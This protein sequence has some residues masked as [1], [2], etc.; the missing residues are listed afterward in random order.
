MAAGRAICYSLL[1]RPKG[2]RNRAATTIA[3]ANK[4][5]IKSFVHISNVF[6]KGRFNFVFQ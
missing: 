3:A 4:V 6:V 5:L 1:R 2:R